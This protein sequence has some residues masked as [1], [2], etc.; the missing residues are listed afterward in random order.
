MP[1][2]RRPF[3]HEH[4]IVTLLDLDQDLHLKFLVFS[5][6]ILSLK[7]GWNN[8][9]NLTVIFFF[10]AHQKKLEAKNKGNEVEEM[11]LLCSCPLFIFILFHPY[12][13]SVRSTLLPYPFTVEKQK[14]VFG[15]VRGIQDLAVEN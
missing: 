6:N 14:W 7:G 8:N 5:S 2:G 9:N 12:K 4:W 15:E 3:G 1:G 11:Y 13:N 10:N